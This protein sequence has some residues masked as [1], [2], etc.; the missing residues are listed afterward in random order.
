[1]FD[2]TNN[3]TKKSSNNTQNMQA[4]NPFHLPAGFFPMFFHPAMFNQYNNDYNLPTNSLPQ[5]NN[6]ISLP[7][8]HEFFENLEKLMVNVILKK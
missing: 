5:T 2:A 8:I 3:S 6:S 7:T 1:M 4:S